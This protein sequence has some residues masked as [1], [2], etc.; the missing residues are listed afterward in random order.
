M[1][2]SIT[3]NHNLNYGRYD[4]GDLDVTFDTFDPQDVLNVQVQFG[5]R[6]LLE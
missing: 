4:Y 5:V 1:Q 6:Y 2:S 3:F